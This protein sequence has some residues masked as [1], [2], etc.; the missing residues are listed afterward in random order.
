MEAFGEIARNGLVLQ[1]LASFLSVSS[2][3]NAGRYP[4]LST[5]GVNSI[6]QL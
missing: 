2:S 3:N 4:E 5:M 1:C 6:I